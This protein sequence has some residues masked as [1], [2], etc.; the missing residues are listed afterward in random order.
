MET[1][2]DVMCNETMR[3]GGGGGC[4]LFLLI[5]LEITCS[6]PVRTGSTDWVFVVLLSLS[7]QM[8]T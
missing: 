3:R 1:V 2:S 8:S 7:L 5:A 6:N 4:F